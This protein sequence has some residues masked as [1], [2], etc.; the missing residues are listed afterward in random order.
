MRGYLKT[1]GW[2]FKLQPKTTTVGRHKDSDL[3]LENGSVEEHH[4]LI[5]LDE[6]E[7]CFVLRDMNSAHGTYVNKCHIHNAGVRLSPGDELHFGY[8]GPTFQ[9]CVESMPQVFP[10]LASSPGSRSRGGP[11]AGPRPPSRGRPA[12]A[13]ATKAKL[14]LSANH[15]V[16]PR[17]AGTPAGATLVDGDPP[18]LDQDEQALRL[19]D[20]VSRLAPFESE[21]HRKDGVIARL[22]DQV[23]VL[24]HQVTQATP[25]VNLRLLSLER[26]ISEKNEQIEELKEQ[27]AALQRGSGEVLKQSLGERDL[28][29]ASLRAQLEKLKRDSSASA[30]LV[31]NLQKDLSTQEKKALALAAEVERL[32]QDMRRKDA[33][34]ANMTSKVSPPSPP[35]PPAPPHTLP[36]LDVL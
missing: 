18:C 25:E 13:G 2:V 22:R 30:G 36:C 4:A 11:A 15:V 7:R 24:R 8:G 19:G 1:L 23:S 16:P 3:C 29:I 21:S 10:H 6:Q 12:N 9:L 20:E 33:Q 17:R 27:M 31:T 28:K 14:G 34:L 32:R 35:R 5:E 26:D